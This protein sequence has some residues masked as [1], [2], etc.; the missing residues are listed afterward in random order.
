MTD[1]VGKAV[2][3]LQADS[4]GVKTGAA[5]AERTLTESGGRAGTGF[6]NSFK[7][8][9]TKSHGSLGEGIAQGLG[10]VSILG[11]AHLAEEAIKKVGE[12]IGEAVNAAKAAEVENAKLDASLAAN[13]KGWDGNTTAIEE[14]I[15]ARERLGFTDS[16]QK[17]ALALLV[18]HTHDVTKALDAERVAMDLARLKG[19]DLGTASTLVGKAFD[20]NVTALKR[21]GIELPKGVKGMDALAAITKVAGGQADAFSKTTEGAGQAVAAQWEGVMERLGAAIIPVEQGLMTLAA[22]GIPTV[23]NAVDLLTTAWQNMLDLI[24][25]GGAELRNVNAAL[26]AMAASLG[27]PTDTLVKFKSAQDEANKSVGETIILDDNYRTELRQLTDQIMSGQGT[28]AEK[29]DA[30]AAATAGLKETYGYTDTAG[31]ALTATTGGLTKAQQ[32]ALDIINLYLDDQREAASQAGLVAQAT[33]DQT[34]A[35]AASLP[36]WSKAGTSVSDL[37][38]EIK[39]LADTKTYLDGWNAAWMGAAVETKHATGTIT[40][41]VTALPYDMWQG[42]KD[43]EDA[44]KQGM[45]DLIYAM[46]HPWEAEKDRA[47]LLGILTGKRLQ[48]GLHSSSPFV[49]SEAEHLRSVTLD[50]LNGIPAKT[51]DVG[52]RAGQNLIAGLKASGYLD[53]V[54]GMFGLGGASSNRH[55]YRLTHGSGTRYTDPLHHSSGGG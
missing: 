12:V 40:E 29:A 38:A 31:Q 1:V 34:T 41:A 23:L 44:V 14:T 4:S 2:Y 30:L 51:H 37:M 13:V 10:F 35:V 20:G 11:A 15:K 9:I 50:A 49:R 39:S 36:Y 3:E 8:S 47:H 33:Q 43:G 18:V 24:D 7:E 5:S 32:E 25:P 42:L 6:V 26:R 53:F 28:A 48:E 54:A 17:D 22:D 45:K 55:N 27:L 46:N 16:A 52:F 19:I 21:L